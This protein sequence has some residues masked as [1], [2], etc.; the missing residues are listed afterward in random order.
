M[1]RVCVSSCALFETR[2]EPAASIVKTTMQQ[3]REFCGMIDRSAIVED[4]EQ[5]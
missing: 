3:R 5:A 2:D 4:V 1:A